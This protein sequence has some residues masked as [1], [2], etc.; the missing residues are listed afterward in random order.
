VTGPVTPGGQPSP[1]G[2]A[3]PEGPATP[4][5]PGAPGALE[6]G[7]FPP[8]GY[9]VA[10]PAK[11]S[12][13]GKMIGII[14]GV[15]LLLVVVVFGGLGYYFLNK[16]KSSAVNATVGNCIAADTVNSTTT[17]QVGS[18]KVVDCGAANANYKVL[19]KV[20]GKTEADMNADKN[21]TMCSPYQGAD[22]AFWIG[23]GNAKGSVLCVQTL[24]K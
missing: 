23:A 20:D 4:G 9:P 21:N 5:Q 16:A 10:P 12:R 14:A 17:Q 13:A 18:V 7:A 6:G 19:G 2:G 8:P 3:G 22:V 11:K 24:K 15:V 1:Y